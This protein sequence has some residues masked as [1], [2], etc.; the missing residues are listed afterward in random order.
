MKPSF[1]WSFPS[2]RGIQARREYYVVMCPL[3]IL[4]K[5]F[6]F[7]EEELKP[8][9]RAQ[10]I[11]NKARL[12]ELR[13]Y[14]LENSDGYVF[15]ALTASVDG[16]VEFEPHGTEGP[17]FSLGV[18][19]VDISARFIINDGQHRRAA[20]ELALQDNPDL[21]NETISI[22]L[23]IDKGLE[24]CQQMFADLNRHAVRPSTSL[25]LLYEHR[26]SKAQLTKEIVLK[27]SIFRD[28]VEMERSSLATRSRKLFTLSAVH[29]ATCALL[30]DIE[31]DQ[32]E[33][34]REMA[35]TYWETVADQIPEWKLVRESKLPA[36]D[37]RRDYIH[38]HG[39]ALHALGR[40]GNC[41]LRDN[42]TDFHARLVPIASI[43]WSRSNSPT[44]EGRAMIG[45]RVSKATHNVILTSNL[46]KQRLQI[47]L[48][49][50]ERRVE[51]AFQRG[52]FREQ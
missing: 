2:I 15:S 39:I 9:L 10:R 48:S 46:I 38:S 20:I 41:L 4:P 6:Q 1:G 45:G 24:R 50:E 8:E 11:L 23:Y 29:T 22:V 14:I 5:I 49:I 37:V 44:W 40:V 25:G 30:K 27:S 13:N 3:R 26:D 32:K 16:N 36:G 43:D 52:E 31:R 7:D 34:L 33:E 21:A 17:G 42:A 12:P 35:Q 19:H 18:L 51:D 28:F 47:E